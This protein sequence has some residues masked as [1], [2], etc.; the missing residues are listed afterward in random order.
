MV[1]QRSW[2][3]PSN[4]NAALTFFGR[5]SANACASTAASAS[6]AF[7]RLIRA[8]VCPGM[9]STG[10]SRWAF[11]A[12]SSFRRKENLRNRSAFTTPGVIP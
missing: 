9:P 3:Y 11:I 1:W 6:W 7:V 2:R 5:A 4:W 12:T 8:A 10:Y